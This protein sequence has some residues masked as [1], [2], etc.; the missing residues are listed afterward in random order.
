MADRIE[1]VPTTLFTGFFGTGK[2]T[3]ITSMLA[4]KPAGEKWAILINEFGEVAVDQAAVP[5]ED[6][7][8]AINEIPGGCLCC[9]MN[10]PLKVAVVDILRRARPDRLIIEPTGIGHPAGILDQLRD[11]ELVEAVSLR[12]VICL[13][14][15]R[16]I[17]D[18]RLE[19][20]QVYQDQMHLADVLVAAKADL[21]S[22]DELAKFHEWA[23]SLFPPK[24]RIT[25]SRHGDLD[26]ALLN[27]DP[28]ETRAPLFPNAHDGAHDH[29]H[30]S[31]ATQAIAP[32]EQGAPVR[33]ENAGAGY[34]GCG[35]IFSET[36]VFD[37]DALLDL[38]GPPGLSGLPKGTAVERLKGVFRTNNGWLLIDRVDN[39]ITVK[40]IAYRRDS[41]I[42]VI[43]T[44]S[45]APDWDT[46]EN[47]L[48][49][50]A[51]SS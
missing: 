43:V 36:Q 2:T 25:E 11:E 14:D 3:A 29:D 17:G 24:L 40:E 12:A 8:V 28:T 6:E 32:P 22:G 10:V 1:H 4:R 9:M 15:P 45:A 7:T 35:W 21:A 47:A 34:Q 46:L 38:L 39:E 51:I 33:L 31:S 41:R 16:H 18:P 5:A 44:D 50:S 20:A 13:V 30:S 48:Q 19:A 49:A 27:L 23:G 37:R 26:L 42:E